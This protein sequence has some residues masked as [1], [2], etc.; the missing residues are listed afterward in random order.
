MTVGGTGLSGLPVLWE[1]L[2]SVLASL[3]PEQCRKALALLGETGRRWFFTGQGRSGLVA[4]MAAMRFMHLGAESHMV[5]EVTAPS[6]R[7]NDGLLL[8]SGSGETFV[9]L[10]FARL[11]KK[12]GARLIVLTINPESSLARLADVLIEIPARNSEQFG[13]SLFEQASL[14]T[15]DALVLALTQ[16]RPDL[17]DLMGVRHT[18]FQ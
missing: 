13:G 11:A 15:L 18:N 1:E 14:L 10:H 6:I 16:G 9:S 12:E 17:Y 3:K 2:S 7:Q 4:Q 8:V 5:G